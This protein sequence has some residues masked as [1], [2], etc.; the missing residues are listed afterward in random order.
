MVDTGFERTKV[1]D[2]GFGFRQLSDVAARALSPGIN[3]PTTAVHV[4]GHLSDL[5]CRLADR[6]PG[7][8]VLTDDAD[9]VRV[10]LAQPRFGDFLDLALAQSRHYGAGD[11][12][13]A[14]RLL[15]LLQEISWR[16]EREKY[17][18]EVLVQLARIREAIAASAYTSAERQRLLDLTE[19][20]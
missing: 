11:P 6:S 17:R 18:S 13:V 14:E 5:L 1:Q 9:E 2:V 16:D 8:E 7:P 20:L 4:I 15:V 12:A 3:D 10:I 19:V